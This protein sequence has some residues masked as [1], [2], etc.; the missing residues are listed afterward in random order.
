MSDLPSDVFHVCGKY[1]LRKKIGSGSFGAQFQ[2]KLFVL[3]LTDTGVHQGTYT[4]Q[5]ILLQERK[6]PSRWNPLTPIT[7]YSSMNGVSTKPWVMAQGYLNLSGLAAS[8]AIE[9]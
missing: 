7:H 6:L 1:R 9:H 8:M 3:A 2:D 4:L 5:M